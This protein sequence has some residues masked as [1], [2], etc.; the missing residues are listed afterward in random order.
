MKTRFAIALG[1]FSTLSMM[2]G[3]AHSAG[4][5]EE[6]AVDCVNLMR[7]DRTHVVDDQN[8]LFYMRGDQ[9]YLN[10]LSH[11]VP[12]LDPTEALMYRTTT[13]RLCRLD[14][15]TVLERWGFGLTEGAS[16]VLGTFMPVDK[17]QAHALRNGKVADL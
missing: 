15:V 16:G 1:I 4:V 10:R 17:E 2:A 11:P 12:G 7:V 14:T 8:I 9:I 5:D 3:A 6:D 13:S